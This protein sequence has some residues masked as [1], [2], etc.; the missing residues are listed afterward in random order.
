M[1]TKD[2]AIRVYEGEALDIEFDI[3]TLNVD[4]TTTVL[5][6]TGSTVLCQVRN[7]LGETGAPVLTPT[8]TVAAPTTGRIR[9]TA[10]S[11]A[12]LAIGPGERF[13][14]IVHVASGADRDVLWVA[15]Y[16]VMPSVTR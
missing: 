15:P 4:G 6:L 16:I 3:V 11:S 1:V 8:V 5:N 2:L 12:H 9:L 13:Y 10:P 7:Q 14:D